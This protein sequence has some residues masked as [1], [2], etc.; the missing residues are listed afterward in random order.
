MQDGRADNECH[1]LH[2]KYK[3]EVD[4]R[5]VVIS[6]NITLMR[7]FQRYAVATRRFIKIN[8]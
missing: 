4:S 5:D 8:I 1:C 2:S 6:D 3:Y 7:A